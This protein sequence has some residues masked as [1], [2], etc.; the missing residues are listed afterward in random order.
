MGP[1]RTEL[2]LLKENKVN[3][4]NLFE[5][6]ELIG[7]ECEKASSKP[8]VLVRFSLPVGHRT[9]KMKGRQE[10]KRYWENQG[11]NLL[12]HD[13]LVC[14][15]GKGGNAKHFAVVAKREPEELAGVSDSDRDP[16][17]GLSIQGDSFSVSDM[18]FYIGRGAVWQILQVSTSYF[19][20]Q[21]VLKVLQTKDRLA[22]AE[23]ILDAA[24][25]QLTPEY[26]RE[27][28]VASVYPTNV[29]PSQQHALDQALSCR[30]A[31]LQGPPGTGKTFIASTICEIIHTKSTETIL[32]V[33]YTNHALDQ[34][35]ENL[36]SKGITDMVRIG[37]RSK[38]AILEPYSLRE[39]A[40]KQGKGTGKG[41]N[42]SSANASNRRRAG[43]LYAAREQLHSRVQSLDAALQ[44]TQLWKFDSWDETED[45]LTSEGYTD[46][47]AELTD[48]NNNNADG[49]GFYKV[50]K[51]LNR[52][53]FWN[54]WRNGQTNP[55]YNQLPPDSIWH[56]PKESRIEQMELWSSQMFRDEREELA[57]AMVQLK[58]IQDDLHLLHKEGHVDILKAARVIGCTT[59]GAAMYVD[60]LTAVGPSVVM[61]EEA[62]ELLE[63]HTLTSM[64]D[65]TQHLIQI[66]DHKQLR[67]KLENHELSVVSGNGHDLNQSMFERLVISGHN[68]SALQEQHRMAPEISALIMNMGVYPELTDHSSVARHPLIRGLE[69]R[70]VFFDHRFLEVEQKNF[71]A[72][73]ESKSNQGEARMA[74]CIARYMIQ[75]AYTKGQITILTSYLGQVIELQK[76][77]AAVLDIPVD[78]S[79]RDMKDLNASMNTVPDSS[80]KTATDSKA[81]IRV[82][83]IDNYQVPKYL[84]TLRKE[85]TMVCCRVKKT[86]SSSCH[87][88]VAMLI[89]TLGF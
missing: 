22:L 56:W 55:R 16:Q 73:H 29:N 72:Q 76:A 8:C 38:S 83:T 17:I 35:L 74:A 11:K 19:S 28:E 69:S 71:K 51:G 45:F 1:A 60:L 53:A 44:D 82:S 20:Y 21:P 37:G 15:V 14:L 12:P 42:R 34:L 3:R 66:G 43:M 63:A 68:H 78:I 41:A 64:H 24:A 61:T 80:T 10:R 39:I 27:L 75:Q 54:A 50:G 87:W 79:D 40:T 85:L 62:G 6:V 89:T 57:E 52:Y 31:L 49:D 26:L 65:T 59:T 25:P 18:L 36:L 47:L 4:R 88:F 33:A 32:I 48:S 7:I 30:V 5:N 58:Q 81:T 13:A 77:L 23:E 46:I 67:P 84:L 9:E 70:V 2:K 86:I